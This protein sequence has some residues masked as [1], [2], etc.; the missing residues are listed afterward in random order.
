MSNPKSFPEQLTELLNEQLAAQ[1]LD[2]VYTVNQL[3]FGEPELY[4][5]DTID[6]TNPTARNSRIAITAVGD[7][8]VEV[9]YTLHYNRLSLAQ[10]VSVMG[11]DLEGDGSQVSTYDLLEEIAEKLKLDLTGSDLEDVALEPV[12]AT[13]DTVVLTAKPESLG[14]FGAAE[15][16]MTKPDPEAG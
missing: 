11:D 3:T 15:M 9:S 4:D 13:T 8:E 14:L 12:N 6:L 1:N 7:D 16:T 5:E 10:L 2:T